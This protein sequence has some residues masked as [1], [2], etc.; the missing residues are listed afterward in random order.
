MKL[1]SKKANLVGGVACIFGVGMLLGLRVPPAIV[2]IYGL[3]VATYGISLAFITYAKDLNRR[4]QRS[5]ITTVCMIPQYRQNRKMSV[6][7]LAER[8]N[9]S[10]AMIRSIEADK[11]SPSYEIVQKIADEFNVTPGSLFKKAEENNRKGVY[12]D[13]RKIV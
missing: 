2:L 6:E 3:L 8:V 1:L 10:P 12:V 7:E 11:Y 9:V 4:K 5:K 13:G